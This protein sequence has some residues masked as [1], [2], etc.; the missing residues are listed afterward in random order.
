[1]KQ[2]DMEMLIQHWPG[3]LS[4]R[5][6]SHR[7]TYINRN[8]KNWLD[9]YC[10][11]SPIGFTGPEVAVDAP[12]NVATMLLACHDASLEFIETGTPLTKVIEFRGLEGTQHF[13]VIK[14]K[15]VIDG[16]YQ[17][18]TTGFDVTKL[19]E[20]AQ[21]YQILSQTDPL[22][23]LNNKEAVKRYQANAGI[24]I[25][26]D[27]NN[28]KNVNDTDGH[29]VGDEVLKG[30]ASLMESHFRPADFL[31]R[32]G[33]DEFLVLSKELTVDMATKRLETMA[34]KFSKQFSDHKLLGIAYGIAKFDGSWEE[35]F[36][37]ADKKMYTYKR[38]AKHN[39]KTT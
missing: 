29:L 21:F 18:F 26:I 4:V 13:N 12:D 30:F 32:I 1:M 14:F 8:F 7:F 2:R 16:Q 27:L 39:T 5:D 9:L 10:V 25:V 3:F 36:N 34:T 17:I 24:A 6:S 20:T 11:K 19:H 31:A 22:T 23:G 37:A 28:F 15:S 33:G 38:G 35:T